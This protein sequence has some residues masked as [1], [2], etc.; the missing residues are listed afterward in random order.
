MRVCIHFLI[1]I[2]SQGSLR[3]F[4]PVGVWAPDKGK[5]EQGESLARAF[6]VISNES[7]IFL[8]LYFN[9]FPTWISG[10][11]LKFFLS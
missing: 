4:S 8:S 10:L 5:K 7:N 2:H 11:D 1:N 3:L 9:R 6:M